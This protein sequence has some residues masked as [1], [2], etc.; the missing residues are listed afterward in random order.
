MS[1][2]ATAAQ[3]VVRVTFL[4][5]IVLGIG[6]WTGHLDSLV[7]LHIWSGI[8]LV[9]GLWVL[10]VLAVRAGAPL[11]QVIAAGVWGA[12]VIVVGLTHDS[13]LTGG[14][15]WVIQ[16]VHLLLGLGAVGMAEGLGRR[17]KQAAPAAAPG[18]PG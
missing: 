11:G 4:V 8:L 3:I 12:V 9:L 2:T 6:F 14:W 5:Q 10:A 17:I 18:N 7:P 16:V 13:I 1:R 15:H